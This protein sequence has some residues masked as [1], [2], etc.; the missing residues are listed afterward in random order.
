MDLCGVSLDQSLAHPL[1]LLG[2][3]ARNGRFLDNDLGGG[4]DLGNSAGGELKVAALSVATN[5]IAKYS[6]QVGSESRSNTGLLGGG[7]NGNKDEAI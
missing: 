4:R 6:L 3:T 2:S 5:N 1:N 7:V